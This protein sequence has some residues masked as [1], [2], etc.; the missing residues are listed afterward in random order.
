MKLTFL[1]TSSMVPTADRNTTAILLNYISENILID[2]GEGTQRQL[3]KVKVSPTKITKILITHWHGDHVLGLPGLLETLAKSEYN[4][5]LEIYGPSGT[6]KFIKE[7]YRVFISQHSKINL[8][9]RDVTKN[10]KFFENQEFALLAQKLDHTSN[11]YGYSFQERDK[12][13]INLTYTKKFG[14]TKSP[15]LGK[16][17]QGKTITYQGKK[18]TP[19][20][21]IITIP[22]KKVTFLIDSKKIKEMTSLAKNSDILVSEATFTNEQKELAG[23]RKHMTAKQAAEVAKASKSKKLILTHFSQRYQSTSELEKEAKKIFKNTFV[24]KDFST[25]DV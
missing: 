21:G 25:F 24:A 13:K 11:C 18:I 4:K 17:Q 16:L 6:K 15:L 23:K 8:K 19:K 12:R 22:G 5:T 2:C 20:L 3:R 9:V 7:L 1:G 14:L 10:G